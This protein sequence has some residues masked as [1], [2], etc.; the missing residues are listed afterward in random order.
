VT[1]ILTNT[2]A[3][4]YKDINV[5]PK[6]QS[7]LTKSSSARAGACFLTHNLQNM[8][9]VDDYRVFFGLNL[10]KNIDFFTIDISIDPIEIINIGKVDLSVNYSN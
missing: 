9:E 6:L 1:T 10:L 7:S 8:I 3:V 2:V 5:T 4:G